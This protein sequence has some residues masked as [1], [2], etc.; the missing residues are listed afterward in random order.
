M[1]WWHEIRIPE[2]RAKLRKK[3][4]KNVIAEARWIRLL[5]PEILD[6]A[7]KEWRRQVSGITIDKEPAPDKDDG[8]WVEKN[9]K[10]YT[11]QVSIAS[12]TELFWVTSPI[13]Q[14]ALKRMTSI[15]FKDSHVYHMV[16]NP[17]S[18]DAA[19]LNDKEH[20]LTLTA[21]F[22]IN[23]NF[24][25]VR[26]DIFPSIFFNKQ[27]TDHF[28]F[29][30][31]ITDVSSWNYEIFAIMHELAR[32]LFNRRNSEQ[33][34]DRF[35]DADE[36]IVVWERIAWHSNSHI[37][38]FV[39]QEFMILCNTEVLKFCKEEGFPSVFRNHMPD[40]QWRELPTRLQNAY[41]STNAE[42]HRALDLPTY[43][44][45][46]SPIRRMADHVLHINLLA[47]LLKNDIPIEKDD[48]WSLLG[49]LNIFLQSRQIAQKQE[50]TDMNWKRV[51]RKDK[52]N[53]GSWKWINAHI[54]H[55]IQ[56]K[57]L[58]LSDV[59]RKDIISKIESEEILNWYYVQQYLFS[60]EREII[61]ALQKRILSEW[62]T[63]RYLWILEWTWRVSFDET[64]DNWDYK[65]IVHL[66]GKRVRT[67]SKWW[68]VTARKNA[69]AYIFNSVLANLD[70]NAS[71]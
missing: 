2:P 56:Q 15:Y 52:R 43:W 12:I 39:I 6:K 34:I 29:R 19:S 41:Y 31:S 61:E 42:F 58:T 45:F 33:R 70:S 8:I 21:E 47:H 62:K 30:D 27:A 54:R 50:L 51:L 65:L 67:Y 24:E 64:N 35:D 5:L 11:L 59:V 66:K 46:T 28:Q 10:N 1:I 4:P 3:H 13:F 25:V 49:I 69:F 44:H 37:A 38:S 7:E 20:R 63:S 22:E 48:L 9:W 14:E 57:N 55:V 23:E 36:R 16:P 18:I 40:Y 53:N 17:I 60:E 32:W 68:K 71:S 26:S